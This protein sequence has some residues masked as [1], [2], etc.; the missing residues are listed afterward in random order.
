MKVNKLFGDVRFMALLAGIAAMCSYAFGNK[1][2]LYG[3]AAGISATSFSLIALWWVIGIVARPLSAP[4]QSRWRVLFIIFCF[5]LKIPI[6]GGAWALVQR[7]SGVAPAHFLAGLFLVYSYMVGWAL[8]R[9]E[10]T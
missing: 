4:S 8:A 2:G 9:T 5:L 3:M 10:S 6:L 7:L 1:P